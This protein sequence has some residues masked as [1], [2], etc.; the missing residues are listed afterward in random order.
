MT[1]TP[2]TIFTQIRNQANEQSSA[3]WSDEE[4]YRI[5]SEAENQVAGALKCTQDSTSFS[6]ADGTREYSLGADVGQISRLTWD[7]YRLRAIDLNNLDVVEGSAYGGA[8]QSGNPQYYYL[9]GSSIGLSPVPDSAKTCTIYHNAIPTELESTS[10]GF[11]IP[12]QYSYCVTSYTL[13]Q[14]FVKDQQLQEEAAFYQKK[15][16]MD[17]ETARSDWMA[18]NDDRY[19]Q[20]TVV[21]PIWDTGV[22]GVF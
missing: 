7:S 19:Q 17:L 11:T 22:Y 12:S 6:T 20:V 8:D 13:W 10:T 3:F 1:T 18:R 16:L 2:S 4:I 21:D 14:M 5:M 15:Y 9:W